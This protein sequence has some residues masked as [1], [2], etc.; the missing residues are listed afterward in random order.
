MNI[1]RPVGV[2]GNFLTFPHDRLAE[3]VDCNV[4]GSKLKK[5]AEDFTS[6]SIVQIINRDW[7]LGQKV[8]VTGPPRGAFPFV[9]GT[10]RGLKNAGIERVEFSYSNGGPYADTNFPVIHFEDFSDWIRIC[11]VSNGSWPFQSG[12]SGYVC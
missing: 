7:D 10:V 1:E 6:D 11:W 3:V 4:A 12:Q 9:T 5:A 8:L 2:D